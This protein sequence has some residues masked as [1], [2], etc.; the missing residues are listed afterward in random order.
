MS[1]LATF[2]QAITRTSATAPSRM[3]NVRLTGAAAWSASVN[4][5]MPICAFPPANCTS[6]RFPRAASWASA[7]AVVAPSRR[8][9]TAARLS[10][11]RFFR[12]LSPNA[13]GVHTSVRVGNWSPLGSS[14]PRGNAKPGGATPMTVKRSPLRVMR[15]PRIDGEPAHRRRQSASLMSATCA[16]PGNASTSVKSRPMAGCTPRVARR[17]G[18]AF[19][20]ATCSGR[21]PSL[22]VYGHDR[23]AAADASVGT[24]CVTSRYVGAES[25]NLLS[26]PCTSEP[27]NQI[28]TRWPGSRYGSGRRSTPDT[29]VAR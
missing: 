12:S 26:V 11:Q 1:R 20:P 29:M 14:A 24:S 22:S 18:E 25:G 27:I 16:A 15:L 2:T 3:S 7:V 21:I 17:V 6:R 8:R 9:P 4:A 28:M 19:T 23:N 13:S 10:V 5:R